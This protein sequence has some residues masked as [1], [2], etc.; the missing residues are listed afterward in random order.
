VKPQ[1]QRSFQA[2]ADIDIRIWVDFV[3]RFGGLGNGRTGYLLAAGLAGRELKL[4]RD[5]TKLTV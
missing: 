2:Y 5:L 1:E 3:T 4:V